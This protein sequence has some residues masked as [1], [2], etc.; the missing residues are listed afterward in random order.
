MKKFV[1]EMVPLLI[2]SEILSATLLIFGRLGRGAFF[3]FSMENG[4][5]KDGIIN[6]FC[7]IT[8]TQL[9]LIW[10]AGVILCFVIIMMLKKIPNSYWQKIYKF[11][12]LIGVVII[13]VCVLF[14]LSGTSLSWFSQYF[15]SMQGKTGTL[16]RSF[17]PY[18][19]DEFVVNTI[20]AISQ[21]EN[22]YQS[23][24]YFSDIVRGTTTDM[25]IVYGQPVWHYGILFRP[26]QIGYLL[27]GSSQGL[28]FFWCARLIILF[29]VTFD[30]G[31]FLTNNKKK[32][33]VCLAIIIALAPAVQW[34]F[35]I[36]GF[37]EQLIFGQICVL[38][39]NRYMQENPGWKR[40]RLSI[41][42]FW[43]GGCYILVFYPA[44]Q[45]PFGYVFLFLMVAVV[46]RNRK[47]FTWSWKKDFPVLIIVGVI[48]L[49]LLG[50]LFLKSW[51]TIL[52]VLNTAYPGKRVCTDKLTLKVMFAY[53]Y[54]I[55]L[56]F[57][58]TEFNVEWVFI[59][60]FPLG[61]ILSLWLIIKE[62]QRD[63]LLILMNLCEIFFLAIYLLPVP[64][65]LLK[66]TLLSMV[67]S[68]RALI[69][70]GFLNI[71]ILIRAFSLKKGEW[72]IVERIVMA[73]G[74]PIV[75]ILIAR[76]CYGAITTTKF[77]I[78][79][80]A[81]AF[82]GGILL[83]SYNK[84]E[85]IM[86]VAIVSCLILFA[87]CGGL[88]NPLQKG[89]DFIL[90]SPLIEDIAAIAKEN[91]GKW[92]VE[93]NAFPGNNLPLLG[94][95]ATINSTNV[96]PD[97]ER[98]KKLDS[99]GENE[100]IYNRYAHI[101]MEL[102]D[103]EDTSFELIQPDLFKVKLNTKDL[104]KLDVSYILSQNELEKYSNTNVILK[105]VISDEGWFIYQV[106]YK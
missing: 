15:P 96:Y 100:E 42:F 45:I 33:S 28:S 62:K 94:G 38:T 13:A 101:P 83:L 44:W 6:L 97:I 106:I 86:N 81:I 69:P 23:Y 79:I 61:M 20:F 104:E 56:P 67:P 87:F 58:N 14:E 57:M 54:N 65:I 27:L 76:H 2:E 90:N 55:F 11:R 51:N 68:T 10:L 21:G 39:L 32:L 102:M 71:L 25:F 78:A 35:A 18:R 34:W 103:S 26:F 91:K 8:K 64:E 73:I 59:D 93:G 99:E 22:P 63:V 24:P 84:K 5:T 17:N 49:I 89:I 92:I 53:V 9:C 88:V 4:I 70:M 29:L 47:Q 16:F 82:V 60:F 36:N 37:V 52:T 105:K 74:Y 43:S 3:P 66:A 95:A 31:M 48:W 46:L 1:K 77:M 12:Y 72:N 85:K 7:N 80:M 19:S 41:I 50:S 75:V 30:F 40:V 98:W